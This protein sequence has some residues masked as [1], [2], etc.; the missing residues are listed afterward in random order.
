M[1]DSDLDAFARSVRDFF[2]STLPTV[3]DGVVGDVR[4]ARVYRAALFDAGLAGLDYPR[5][6][7]GQELGAE[8]LEIF[9][10]ESK[11]KVPSENSIFGIGVGMALPT[12]RDH[13]T[14][15]VKERFLAKG[16]RGEE[17]WCQLYSEPG[18]GSDLASLSTKA[19]RDGD[20]WVVTGQKVWTSG[21]QHSDV[22]ILLVRTDPDAPKHRGVTMLIMPMKQPG[23][24]VRPLRQMTGDAEFNEVF[25]DEARVPADWVVGEINDGWRAAVALLAHERIQTGVASMSNSGTERLW[26]RVPIPVVQLIELARQHDRLGDPLVRQELAQLWINERIVGFLRERSADPTTAVSPSIGKLW[27]TIQGRAGNELAARL[28]F[29]MSPAWVDGDEDSE[30]FAFQFLNCRGMSM[31]GGTDEIQKNTLGE[32]VLGLPREPQVDKNTPF[33]EILKGV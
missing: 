33:N 30:F 22:A 31:G 16:L 4:R 26:S 25:F 13:C 11:G 28:Q 18:A 24:T 21:A 10:E 14:E 8:Y 5:S 20:E 12:V 15:P 29:S 2:D 1:T 27:R 7:G 32:R 17:I 23:V 19:I 6:F 9:A 3:L